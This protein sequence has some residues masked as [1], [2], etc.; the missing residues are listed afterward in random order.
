MTLPNVSAVSSKPMDRSIHIAVMTTEVIEALS[1]HPGGT[2]IDATLG[3]GMHTAEL[4]ERSAPDGRVL[5]FDVDPAALER[6]T[7]RFRTEGPR[8]TGVES[9]FRHLTEKA[10][11]KG[12]APVDG[13]LIDLGVSSDELLDPTKG[14]SFQVAGPLD[15][16]LGP[17]AN[18]DGLTAAEIVNTWSAEE[19]ANVLYEYGEERMSRRIAAHLVAT[20]KIKPF[21]TTLDLVEAVRA[22]V[23]KGYERGRIHPATRTFQ[24][25][26]IAVN[27]ELAV[28]KD[29]IEG[30]RAI[31]K[32]G[33][34][35]A[36]ISFHSLE[37]RVVKQA[38]KAA[39]DLEPLT[40]RPVGPSSEEI[41]KNP[42][43]RSA[44]LRAARKRPK[45]I[46][47]I[48]VWDTPTPSP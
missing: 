17:K 24:A 37:D 32:P 34:V 43:A 26:R 7:D 36:I 3:G 45:Q 47:K 27:D 42:R 9:N 41:N 6:A 25:L 46:P 13:I 19:I 11:E 2:Y 1:P 35:L 48:K 16:R 33:G 39:D 38:F 14:L 22:A 5:S 29:A 20:R 31:L 21:A 4:L 28:L 10:K 23:P 15:M 8:W 12:F 30:S 44:K 18:D 40:K